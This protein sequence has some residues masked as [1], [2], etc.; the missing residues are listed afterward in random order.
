MSM[1]FER[2]AFSGKMLCRL[3]LI[4]GLGQKQIAA[5]LNITQQAYSKM[6]KKDALTIA[7]LKTILIAMNSNMDELEAIEKIINPF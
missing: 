3:R 5:K 1:N 2:P 6:E 7:L 4:K